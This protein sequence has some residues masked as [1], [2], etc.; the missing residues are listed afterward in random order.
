[1]FDFD[2]T[3]VDSL[4]TYTGAL[5]EACR[6][7]GVTAITTPQDVLALFA[8]NF[9]EGM[10]ERG[11]DDETI[12][13]LNRRS[14]ATYMS[15]LARVRPFPFMTQVLSGLA[16]THHVAVVTSNS[17]DAVV[18]SLRHMGVRGVA[19]VLG[20]EQGL[21]KVAKITGLMARFPDRAPYWFVGDTTGD[22][23]EARLAGA[24]PLGVAWGWHDPA[25]LLAAGAARIVATP[26]ELP[27]IIAPAATATPRQPATA[28]R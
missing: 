11:L 26:A 9:F 16:A 19:E 1:M 13:A 14:A 10:R 24:E 12:A 21:G 25:A 28:E 18:T 5:L 2:G 17:A 27:A 20:A 22:M 3:V 7:C 23:R 4:E 6:H 8:G 15:A